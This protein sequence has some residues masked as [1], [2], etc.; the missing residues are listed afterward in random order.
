MPNR[1]L[2]LLSFTLLIAACSPDQPNP[3]AG[4]ESEKPAQ[5]APVALQPGPDAEIVSLESNRAKAATAS[6]ASALQTELKNAMQQGGPVNAIGVCN[7]TAMPITAK[8]SLEQ[9]LALSRVSRKNR[10]PA[11]APN[12]WQGEVLESFENRKADGEEPATMVWSEIVEIDGKQQFRF[13]QAIP[14][15]ALCLQCHGSDISPEVSSRLA[16]LYPGD[17]ATGYAAG[18][19]RGAFVVTRN[20]P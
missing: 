5:D 7:T 17:K 18:D 15:G 1:I 3:T 13:M 11:S 14:T 6:F 16:E 10:N 12:D 8:V 9:G 19:I 4:P 20:L 2:P